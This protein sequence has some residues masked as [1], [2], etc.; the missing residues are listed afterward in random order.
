MLKGWV[1]RV[2]QILAMDNFSGNRGEILRR[3]TPIARGKC[4]AAALK[5]RQ[6]YFSLWSIFV[7][8]ACGWVFGFASAIWVL[9]NF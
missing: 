1:G 7:A 5:P 6:L 2:V 4:L 9:F 3:G 8:S